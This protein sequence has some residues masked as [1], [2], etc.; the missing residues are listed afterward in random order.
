MPNYQLKGFSAAAR[1]LQFKKDET[2]KD[3]RDKNM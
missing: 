1:M 3:V 2:V